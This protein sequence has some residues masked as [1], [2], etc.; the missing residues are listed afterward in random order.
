MTKI[1]RFRIINFFPL[2][3]LPSASKIRISPKTCNSATSTAEN[4]QATVNFSEFSKF[5][6]FKASSK[7][8]DQN[9][10]VE[11]AN[12]M[13]SM[14]KRTGI[15]SKSPFTGSSKTASHNLSI[16]IIQEIISHD[17]PYYRKLAFAVHIN[18]RTHEH[19]S[20]HDF[21]LRLNTIPKRIQFEESSFISYSFP[22]I[23]YFNQCPEYADSYII[24]LAFVHNHMNSFPGSDFP[25]ISYIPCYLQNSQISISSSFSHNK[26]R[27]RLS[28]YLPPIVNRML[29]TI[30]LTRLKDQHIIFPFSQRI[31]RSRPSDKYFSFVSM[32]TIAFI[33]IRIVKE[34]LAVHVSQHLLSLRCPFVQGGSPCHFLNYSTR[35]STSDVSQIIFIHHKKK[36]ISTN[37]IL[38]SH[39]VVVP[40]FSPSNLSDRIS[41]QHLSPGSRNLVIG[42]DYDIST[43]WGAW[44]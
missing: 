32:S 21:V 17:A 19:T 40:T 33:F 28:P 20:Y 38:M 24:H 22:G 3:F 11:I 4:Y 8:S 27:S 7:M 31:R 13:A 16:T 43:A 14:S 36:F 37:V 2:L 26:R 1:R 35:I 44:R 5:S 9:Q 30:P 23:L 12:Q 15:N 18:T 41:S 39:R 29:P 6:S 10:L 25:I 34:S 42:F